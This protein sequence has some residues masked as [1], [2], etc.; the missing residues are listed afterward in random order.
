M[1]HSLTILVIDDDADVLKAVELGL[2]SAGWRIATTVN[3][4]EGVEM[5]R[6]IQPNVIVC[7]SSMPEF[8]G[9]QVIGML[10]ND[11]ATA[12]IPVVLMTGLA[13]VD[14]L[15]DVGW[16]TFL[17]KPFGPKELRAAIESTMVRGIPPSNRAVT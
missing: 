10:K 17:A 11:P 2:R 8:S 14:M 15:S 5:A 3:P 1:N 12:D 4:R 7:D 6:S 9:A 16:T 13:E